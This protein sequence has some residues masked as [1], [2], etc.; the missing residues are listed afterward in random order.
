M[1]PRIM[2]GLDQAVVET[3]DWNPP[4]GTN[5]ASRE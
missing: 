5:E 1:T 4:E 3:T 2:I